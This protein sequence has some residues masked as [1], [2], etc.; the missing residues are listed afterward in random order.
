MCL[1]LPNSGDTLKLLIP[2]NIGKSISGWI[3]YSGMV[4]SQKMIE[5][6]IGNC[7]SKSEYKSNL[8]F[9]KEQRVDGGWCSAVGRCSLIAFKNY[10]VKLLLGVFF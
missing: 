7:G 8:Y 3:N 5:R 9:V 2:N 4:T 10:R 1:Q 6:E